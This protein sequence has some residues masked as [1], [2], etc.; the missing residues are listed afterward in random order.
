MTLN[1]DSTIFIVFLAL[2]VLI[3]LF[4]SYGVTNIKEYAIGDK[5]FTTATI[6]ATVV[7]T[8]G[9][10]NAF[11]GMVEETYKNGLY[12]IFGDLA[13]VI[14]MFSIG[15]I[16]APRMSEFLNKLS[17]AEAMGSLYGTRVRCITAVAG[18][19]MAVG[20][21][22]AQLQ[23]SGLIF[24]YCF[25]CPITYGIVIGGIIMGFYS[26][27]GGVRSVTFTDVI[28]LLT[29]ATMLPTLVFFIF[30][31]MHMASILSN[32][33]VI[34]K[35]FN[36]HEVFDFTKPKSLYYLCLFLFNGIPGF[37]PAFFQRVAIAKDTKQITRSFVVAG[38]IW[39]FIIL[40]IDFISI[41]TFSAHPDLIPIN[42]VKFIIFDQSYPGLRGFILAGIMAM[43]MSTADSYTNSASVLFVHDLCKPLGIKIKRELLV[44]RITSA[45]LVLGAIGLGLV[46]NIGTGKFSLLE[47][48]IATHM[49]YMP[50][51]TVPFI[52]AVFGFR[53][54]SRAVL[55]GMTAGAITVLTWEQFLQIEYIPGIIPGMFANLVFLFSSH[56]ILGQSGGWIGIKDESPLI[57]IRRERK[58]KM[59][60]FFDSIKNFSFSNFMAK[61]SPNNEL[62]YVYTGLFCFISLYANMATI[63][64]YIK[65]SFPD[66]FQFITPSVLFSATALLSYPLWLEPWKRCEVIAHIVWNAV[67]LYGLVFIG[68]ILAIIS[69]F[70][71]FQVMILII[72]LIMI[73]VLV[74]WQW[75]L[76]IVVFGAIL[77]AKFV[78][79]YL[80]GAL[81]LG[82]ISLKLQLI[83]I[84]LFIGSLLIIFIKPKQE[85]QS[86]IEEK[87]S[88]LGSRL[89]AQEKQVV[90]ALSL[91]SEFIRNMQHEYHTPMTGIMA[92]SQM[93]YDSHNNLSDKEK[94]E[95]AEVIFKSFV[96]LESFDSNLA[97]LAKLSNEEF[98]IK[99]EDIDFSQLLQERLKT[100]RKLYEEEE[101][102]R[103]F[104]VNLPDE[105][106]HIRGDRYYLQ[107]ML[108]NL[109]INAINYCEHG[110]IE[111]TL[112]KLG[113]KFLRLYIKDSGIG[114]PPSEL[115]EVFGEF[116]ISSKTRTPS[117]GRGIGLALC[118]KVVTAHQGS[119]L[120]ESD[121]Q[122]WTL[123]TVT[124]PLK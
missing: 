101:S 65:Q 105:D 53:S 6:A 116:M 80:P 40:S 113:L 115:L 14:C 29:F 57:A 93:L 41:L 74:R 36:F 61:N 52:L 79:V 34:K 47:I 13:D 42:V 124:L 67:S 25:N 114:I 56:Y 122:S 107:Q 48:L 90:D 102:M 118:K 59:K 88:H 104:I 120:A 22:A 82:A 21:I 97:S 19:T 39:F 30:D 78:N 110:L 62:M 83:Y 94:K 73:A 76:T 123:L 15:I 99:R 8:W 44:T 84:L 27:L 87:V 2:S 43:I 35:F 100:C 72:N 16:L 26:T 109:I 71:T 66:L 51:V 111:I 38:C 10:G 60:Q 55:I 17:I 119:I 112:E 69:N 24:S 63:N 4:S 18:L 81:N 121:G 49:F 92:M 3:G 77:S 86:L 96:R 45:I 11:F 7:A 64:L 68:F 108:D 54:T 103:E 95:A 89:V 5:N 75:A 12:Q 31:K 33:E 70:A 32:P 1:L 106:I 9:S 28:Q 58:L 46:N 20:T 23:I 50:V 98:E 85:Y 117:G 91:K 37:G